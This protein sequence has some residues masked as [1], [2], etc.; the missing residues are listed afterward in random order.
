MARIL[1]SY[2]LKVALP[3]GAGPQTLAQIVAGSNSRVAIKS[4]ELGPIGSTGASAPLEFDLAI[5]DD[6][7]GQVTG[8]TGGQF[9]KLPPAAA[10]TLQTTVRMFA[11]GTPTEPTTSTVQQRFT[12]HQQGVRK[13]VPQGGEILVLGGTIM[14]LRLLTQGIA[15]SYSVN[16]E[17]EE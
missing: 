15:I 8:D 12:L 5:Q 9:V 10:E 4:I 17:L 2:Q 16:F 7:G 13:W 1:I 11:S 6:A 3:S 14:G